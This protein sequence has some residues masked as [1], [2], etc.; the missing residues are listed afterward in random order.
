MAVN[1]P[2]HL[3]V[4]GSRRHFTLLDLKDPQK[5]IRRIHLSNKWDISN[6]LWNPSLSQSNLLL[7]TVHS[8]S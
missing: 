1:V 6:L 4:L 7:S 2:R 5:I 3:V 8:T